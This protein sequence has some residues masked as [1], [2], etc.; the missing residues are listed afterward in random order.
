MKRVRILIKPKKGLLDPQGRAV[1]E[2]L[3][4]RGFKVGEVQV[5]KVVELSVEDNENIKDIV[6][7]FI[8]NPLIEEY[9]IEELNNGS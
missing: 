6:E 8:V 7:R 3:K 2:L 1:E 5:G 4:D 9:E